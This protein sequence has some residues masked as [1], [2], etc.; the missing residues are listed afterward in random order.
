MADAQDVAVEPR[1][2]RVWAMPHKQTFRILPIKE[3]LY[4]Y[5]LNGKGWADPFAGESQFAEFRNDLNPALG[6]PS[7]M[8]A[9]EFLATLWQGL[10]GVI[11][12]P[13]YSLTQVSRSYQEI[14]LAFKGKENPTG[15]FPRV[16]DEIARLVMP[17]GHVISFGWNTVGMG[18]GRGFVLEEILIVCHGGNHNDTLC[19]V[20]RQELQ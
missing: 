8:E 3:L 7:H 4:R 5:A 10:K 15:G 20:E 14:G 18:I 16:R 13:P 1:I 6:Q 9:G 11:F 2:T 17:G 19:T 12:D